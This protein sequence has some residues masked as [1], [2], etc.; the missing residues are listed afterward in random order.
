[1]PNIAELV[2]ARANAPGVA[3]LF[4]D[5]SYTCPEY[6]QACATRAAYVQAQLP[7]HVG[8]LLDNTPEYVM[9]LGAAALVD[10]VIVGINPTRRGAELARDITHADCQLI[11]T[12]SRH[13]HLLDG[14][15]LGAAAGRELDVDHDR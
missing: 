11:V 4:E 13:A 7:R 6:V 15:E 2:K 10:A 8:L 1:M 3:I 9:W 12:E 14:L 5:A